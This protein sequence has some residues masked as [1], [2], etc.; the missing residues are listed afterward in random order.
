MKFHGQAS[1]DKFR[2]AGSTGNKG[3]T[4]SM[5]MGILCMWLAHPVCEMY[6]TILRYPLEKRHTP[7][8]IKMQMLFWLRILMFRIW[9]DIHLAVPPF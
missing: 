3:L 9:W 8:G 4:E 5:C 6:G 1:N 2:G 7:R